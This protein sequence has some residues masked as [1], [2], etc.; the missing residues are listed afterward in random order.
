MSIEAL[1]KAM[2]KNDPI[3]AV[4]QDVKK[5]FGAFEIRQLYDGCTK[6][7][8]AGL[9]TMA[10]LLMNLTWYLP[11]TPSEYAGVKKEV[12]DRFKKDS[13]VNCAACIELKL[14]RPLP[15]RSS[16]VPSCPE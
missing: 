5:K 1:S 6:L 8:I 9:Q 10:T 15:R 11:P 13:D 14:S 3:A 7:I 2:G 4:Q 12:H 16:P